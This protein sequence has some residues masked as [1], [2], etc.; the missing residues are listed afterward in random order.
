[1]CSLLGLLNPRFLF[2]RETL[3]SFVN[4][5]SD[6]KGAIDMLDLA[7]PFLFGGGYSNSK[8]GR[9]W[10]E[11]LYSTLA[12]PTSDQEDRQWDFIHAVQARSLEDAVAKEPDEFLRC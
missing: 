6:F 11:E 10:G 1:M 4:K 9:T 3:K 8:D 5:K 7:G 2:G 12:K